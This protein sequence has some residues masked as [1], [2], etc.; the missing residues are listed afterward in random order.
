MPH[1]ITEDHIESNGISPASSSE[2]KI[3]QEALQRNNGNKTR[4]AREL[5]VHRSTLWRKI[6]T[7]GIR[8]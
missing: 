5:G 6:K 2:K 4:T 1:N 3:I 8:V 7:Y